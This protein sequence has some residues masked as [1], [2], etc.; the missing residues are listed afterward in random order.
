M[1]IKELGLWHKF[2]I[3]V[4]PRPNESE[5]EFLKK[6]MDCIIKFYE[7]YTTHPKESWGYRH[8]CRNA[9][10][11]TLKGEVEPWNFSEFGLESVVD[12]NKI[13][14][15]WNIDFYV[16]TPQDN[17]GKIGIEVLTNANKPRRK[18]HV[19][20]LRKKWQEFDYIFPEANK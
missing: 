17:Y 19:D 7:K 6:T 10:L 2:L 3:P 16:G 15:P 13:Y 4:P 14:L 5:K 12:P 20:Y 1:E 9:D 8:P 11:E 18:V